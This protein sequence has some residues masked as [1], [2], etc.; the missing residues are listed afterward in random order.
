[1]IEKAIHLPGMTG[2]ANLYQTCAKLM[3]SAGRHQE[4]I[5]LLYKAIDG[6]KIGN[7]VSLYQ[8]CG[9]LMLATGQREKAISLLKKGIAVYPKDKNLR[10]FYEKANEPSS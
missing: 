6:S 9:E 7:L 1:L 2:H 8:L 3:A 5:Q 4:A 10:S